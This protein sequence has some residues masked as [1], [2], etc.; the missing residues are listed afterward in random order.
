MVALYI[1][2]HQLTDNQRADYERLADYACQRLER[3][4]YKA[5]KPACKDCPIHCYAPQDR[6]KIQQ[7]MRWAG[8]RMIFYSP[9]A[10]LH[11]IFQCIARKKTKKKS[12]STK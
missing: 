8:P 11:H 12:P 7:V 9:C 1:R 6:E 10:A 4:R 3:C 5:Q 2:H